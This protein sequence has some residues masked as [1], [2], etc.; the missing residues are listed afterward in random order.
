MK[1]NL[2]KS[3]AKYFSFLKDIPILPII[4]DEQI[5]L[6]TLFFRPI[7]FSKMTDFVAAV[8]KFEAIHTTY[9]RYGGLEFKTRKKEFCHLHGDGLV[10]I[11]LNKKTS[12]L[13][14]KQGL[15]EA[16]HI[17]PNTGWISFQITNT[18]DIQQLILIAQCGY[19]LRRRED[20]EVLILE[21]IEKDNR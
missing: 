5:K 1:L 21:I 17:H 18:S 15:C 12:T 2:T 11:L 6:F 16:H 8:K 13:F 4:L 3:A 19:K 20:I 14:I 7:I 9:H 10:D